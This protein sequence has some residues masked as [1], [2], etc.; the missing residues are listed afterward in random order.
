MFHQDISNNRSAIGCASLCMTHSLC[1]AFTT[2]AK[3]NRC[4]LIRK[5]CL[6]HDFDGEPMQTVYETPPKGTLLL[7]VT[8]FV[9]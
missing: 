5:W 2:N 1:H 8:I 6:N 3:E 7:A 9:N 4:K